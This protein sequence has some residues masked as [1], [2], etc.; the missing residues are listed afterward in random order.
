MKQKMEQSYVLYLE[1]LAHGYIPNKIIANFEYD[2]WIKCVHQ[3]ITNIDPAIELTATIILILD[4]TK[5]INKK[6]TLPNGTVQIMP[7][8]TTETFTCYL[9]SLP[10]DNDTWYKHGIKYLMNPSDGKTAIQRIERSRQMM[11]MTYDIPYQHWKITHNNKNVIKLQITIDTVL[12]SIKAHKSSMKPEW[13]KHEPKP[14]NESL[15]PL[16]PNGFKLDIKT[17]SGATYTVVVTANSTGLDIKYQLYYLMHPLGEQVNHLLDPKG[18]KLVSE[19]KELKDHD[20]VNSL[21]GREIIASMDHRMY[22]VQSISK[23]AHE[24]LRRHWVGF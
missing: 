10:R 14:P 4:N 17:F 11:L 3:I 16:A 23:R 6:V 20:T 22:Y 18:I 5:T 7:Q 9:S 1:N 8:K 21:R 12:N 2:Q 24:Y 15:Q 19:H 13:A